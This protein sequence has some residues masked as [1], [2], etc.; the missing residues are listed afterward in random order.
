MPDRDRLVIEDDDGF[1]TEWPFPKEGSIL[2]HHT[3]VDLCCDLHDKQ[4][5]QSNAR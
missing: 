5:K 1:R 2:H 3:F 4:K